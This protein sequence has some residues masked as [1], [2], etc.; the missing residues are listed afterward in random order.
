MNSLN[1]TL[2]MWAR[3]GASFSISGSRNHIDLERLIL[4]S[5]TYIP[6]FPRLKSMTVAWLSTHE[7]LVSRH[8][9]ASLIKTE[10]NELQSAILGYILSSVKNDTGSSHFNIA[11]KECHPLSI[12]QPLYDIDR[13]NDKTIK[14]AKEFSDAE[15]KNWGLWATEERPYTQKDL[16]PLAWIMKNNPSLH[17]R[18]IF[19][20]KLQSTIISFL[21]EDPSLGSSETRLA[22]TCLST[23]QCLRDALSHL[24]M[25]GLVSRKPKRGLNNIQL[26]NT[27]R[28][29]LTH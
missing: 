1:K 20:G 19:R 22:H 8:R 14:F 7:A 21:L 23:R 2:S 15:G 5:T 9:L 12:F 24:E 29:S 4:Q 6:E 3:L 26:I 18:A 10:A 27:D 11:I 25:C 28:L 13:T 16:R 17:Y